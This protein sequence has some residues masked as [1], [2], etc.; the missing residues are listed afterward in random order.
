MH[1]HICKSEYHEG[2]RVRTHYDEFCAEPYESHCLECSDEE[3]AAQG[4]VW[5]T[6]ESTGPSDA[7]P[8]L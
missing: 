2:R 8:G 1:R 6:G 7:D 5:E 3:L 4:A